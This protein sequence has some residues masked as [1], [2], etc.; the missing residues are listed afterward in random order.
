MKMMFLKA[1]SAESITFLT[2]LLLL[3]VFMHPTVKKSCEKK[4]EK[5]DLGNRFDETT[6]AD[7]LTPC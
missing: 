2:M 6:L 1:S 5:A 7:K 3:F 4:E